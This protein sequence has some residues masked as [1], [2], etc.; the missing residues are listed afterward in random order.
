MK[1]QMQTVPYSEIADKLQAENSR[2]R[3]VLREIADYADPGPD[4]V[5]Q[6]HGRAYLE[7][8]RRARRAAA[9]PEPAPAEPPA[10]FM[11]FDAG[12]HSPQALEAAARNFRLLH[13]GWCS[14]AEIDT[15]TNPP[16]RR[17][18]AYWLNPRTGAHGWMCAACR[19][20]TQTG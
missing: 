1:E 2:L 17:R 4:G 20:T 8:A 13:S 18:E 19:R 9:P 14:C 15:E 5:F 16:T 6:A 10:R 12:D 11:D 7:I 3:Q